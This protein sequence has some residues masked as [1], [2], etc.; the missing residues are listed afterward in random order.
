[1]PRLPEEK[2]DISS[3]MIGVMPHLLTHLV[4]HLLTC[5][6][7]RLWRMICA[8]LAVPGKRVQ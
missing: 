6:L 4:T 3:L 2:D 1:L 5:L 8:A 7:T